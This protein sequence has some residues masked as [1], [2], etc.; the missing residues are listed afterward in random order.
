MFKA[1]AYPINE[2]TGNKMFSYLSTRFFKYIEQEAQLLFCIHGLITM[3][4]EQYKNDN[5]FN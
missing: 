2:V 5:L 3:I 4:T 1:C